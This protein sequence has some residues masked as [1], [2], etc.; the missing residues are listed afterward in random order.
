MQDQ[1]VHCLIY[2]DVL[3]ACLPRRTHWTRTPAS[4]GAQERV[5]TT[6]APEL[7]ATCLSITVSS[8]I[9]MAARAAMQWQC[10]MLG[11]PGATCSSH[12][13]WRLLQAHPCSLIA[14]RRRQVP[15]HVLTLPGDLC[16]V[17]HLRKRRS[18]R[19]HDG[20]RSGRGR[21]GR[22]CRCGR[23]SGCS[24]RRLSL[25]VWL[26]LPVASWRTLAG[27]TA[28]VAVCHLLAGVT[29]AGS[30]D[31][32]LTLLWHTNLVSVGLDSVGPRSHACRS[33]MT[34]FIVL[35]ASNAQGR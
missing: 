25:G 10:A 12:R 6:R 32:H 26:A 3:D 5:L 18:R 9:C 19:C 22:R 8:S 2:N 15:T 16:R 21:D 29:L 28:C 23:Q 20:R 11:A 31:C 14:P 27:R 17:G 7:A 30:T 35:T 13:S 4:G 33:C 34:V 24:Q 1:R